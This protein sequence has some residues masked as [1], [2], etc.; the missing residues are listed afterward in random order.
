VVTRPRDKTI[1]VIDDEPDIREFAARVLELEGYN[2][3]EA[4]DGTEGL[5]LA[6]EHRPAL[7]LLDLRLPDIDGWA[8][9]EEIKSDAE[10]SATPVIVFTAFAAG[11]VR[12]T[13]ISKGA[14]GYLVKPLSSA[15]LREEVARVLRASG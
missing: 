14:A 3:I 12:D 10:L 13:A 7:V 9:L 1:L 11:T 8:V 15:S 6:R 5:S 4:A 2:A